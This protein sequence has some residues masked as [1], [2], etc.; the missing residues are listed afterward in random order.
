MNHVRMEPKMVKSAIPAAAGDVRGSAP[1]LTPHNSS[2]QTD[3]T[4]L[5]LSIL[6]RSRFQAFR[7]LSPFHKMSGELSCVLL[8]RPRSWAPNCFSSLPRPAEPVGRTSMLSTA[9]ARIIAAVLLAGFLPGVKADCWI[10][11]YVLTIPFLSVAY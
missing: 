10:D 7:F 11:S 5:P 6:L 4:P 1:K 2:A 8:C 3:V 9:S